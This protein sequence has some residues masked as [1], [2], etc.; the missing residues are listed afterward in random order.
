MDSDV[1]LPTLTDV[2]VFVALTIA[3]LDISDPITE[4]ASM[5]LKFADGPAAVDFDLCGFIV[6]LG[7]V[8]GAALPS[9]IVMAPDGLAVAVEFDFSRERTKE[10]DASPLRVVSCAFTDT[11]P[12]CCVRSDALCL[13]ADLAS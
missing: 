6:C 11:E 3:F 13:I 9:W 1:S 4:D 10:S 12:V 7:I 2:S 5:T 8:D